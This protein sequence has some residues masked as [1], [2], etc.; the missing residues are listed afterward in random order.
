M[1][2][3]KA[4]WWILLLA[5]IAGSAYW[6]VCKIKELCDADLLGP[7]VSVSETRTEPLIISDSSALHLESQGNFSFARNG[8]VA[9]QTAVQRQLDSLTSYLTA[10]PNR[11]ITVTGY[12]SSQETNTTTFPDLGLARAT[13]IKKWLAGHGIADSLISLESQLSDKLVFTKDSLN[14]GIHFSFGNY[15]APVTAKAPL[16]E[17]DL[18]N[19]QK[20]EN[21]FKPL[22]LYFPTASADYIKTDQNRLFISEAKKYLAE[23]KDKKLILTGHTDDEDSAE[24]NLMLSQKRANAVKSQFIRLGISGDRIFTLGKGES[25]PKASNATPEGKRANRRVAIVVK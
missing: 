23:N 4:L 16:T 6:H 10:N 11:L 15:A 5:W 25:E 20:Y 18:A 24:W 9:S 7:T 19:E 8:I 3:S 2:N 1:S 13:G 21:I 17:T 14:G 12:Y 22:D